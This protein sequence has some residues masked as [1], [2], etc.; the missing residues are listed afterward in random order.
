M[1]QPR[2]TPTLPV[3][4]SE[5]LFQRIFSSP[6]G[7]DPYALAIS[8]VP[9]DLFGKGDPTPGRASTTSTPFQAALADRVPENT[10][11]S[12]DLFEGL[13][14]RAAL[15]TDIELFEESPS[16]YEEAARPAA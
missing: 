5:S 16:H 7:A 13:F 8:D 4:R 3:G 11:L 1:L 14:A 9:L 6:A 10:L 12:H 2:I 15:V